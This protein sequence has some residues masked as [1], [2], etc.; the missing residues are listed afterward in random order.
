MPRSIIP[1]TLEQLQSELRIKERDLMHLKQTIETQRNDPVHSI[2]VF[3]NIADDDAQ[4]LKQTTL[5]KEIVDLKEEIKEKQGSFG[6]YIVSSV[7]SFVGSFWPKKST[8][9]KAKHAATAAH[10]REKYGIPESKGPN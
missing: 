1:R 10:M 4:A 9:D 2:S 8:V 6:S 7:S 3:F 5:E